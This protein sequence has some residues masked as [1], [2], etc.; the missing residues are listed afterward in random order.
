MDT[1]IDNTKTLAQQLKFQLQW[2]GVMSM[3]G[4]E[5]E[6]DTAYVK[7][8]ELAQKLVDIGA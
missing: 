5:D 8:Q 3:A 7:A 4:R 1:T 2:L 6:A